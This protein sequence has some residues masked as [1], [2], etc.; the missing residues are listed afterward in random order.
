MSVSHLD[1]S[2]L[3]KCYKTLVYPYTLLCYYCI[4]L[5][6]YLILVVLYRP[7]LSPSLMAILVLLLLLLLFLLV[8]RQEVI[9][10]LTDGVLSSPVY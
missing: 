7:S 4:I 5:L 8:V 9:L 2:V 1:G 3:S 6:P 10:K